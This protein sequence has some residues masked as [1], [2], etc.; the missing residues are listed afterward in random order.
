MW[1]LICKLFRKTPNEYTSLGVQKIV[2]DVDADLALSNLDKIQEKVE[3]LLE[4]QE[5]LKT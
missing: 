2:I 3:K 4:L 5:K 1:K